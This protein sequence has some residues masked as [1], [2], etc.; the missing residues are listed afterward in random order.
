VQSI[1][2]LTRPEFYDSTLADIFYKTLQNSASESGTSHLP[3]SE[4]NRGLDLVA[5]VQ[6]TQHVILLGLVVVIVHVDAELHFLDRDRLL[7]LFGLALFLLLLVQEFPVIHDAANRR[8]RC[9]GNLYQVKVLF[10]GHLERFE[11]LQDADLLAFIINHANFAG[12]NTLIYADKSFI[13]A[14]LPLHVQRR[15]DR[16]SIAWDTQHSDLGCSLRSRQILC[17]LYG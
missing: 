4:K 10:A 2:F 13:D 3:A 17:D 15:G 5:F 7:V 1:A 8:L 14:N 12:A 9:R 6:K 16:K 11:R